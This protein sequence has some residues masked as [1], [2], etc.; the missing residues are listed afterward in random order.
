MNPVP[1]DRVLPHA[2]EA[3]AAVLGAM[4]IAP[5]VA[6]TLV[7]LLQPDYFY[8]PAHIQLYREITGMVDR[9][10]VVDMVTLSTRLHSLHLLDDVGGP[11]YLVGLL[12]RTP[13]AANVEHYATIVRDRWFL[14]QLILVGSEI[15]S[16]AFEQE[17]D[18][19]AALNE[20][21]AAMFALTSKKHG[22]GTLVPASAAVNE[23][24]AAIQVILQNDG[25]PLGLPT[26]FRKLDRMTGGLMGS[27]VIILGGRASHGKTSLLM[28][29]LEHLAVDQQIPSA[30]FS[31]E[32]GRPELM[33][34]LLCTRAQV[35]IIRLRDGLVEGA[36]LAQ[37]TA[38]GSEIR[39]S[40][41]IIDETPGLTIAQL[42]SRARQLV[43]RDGVKAIGVDY[44]QL[45]RCPSKRAE[46]NR[47]WEMNDVSG[48]VKALAK[49]LQI[50]ILLGAQINRDPE[51]RSDG[52]PR[53]A[54]LRE[55][56][57]IE[58]DADVVGLIHRPCMY[59]EDADPKAAKLILAKQRNGPTGEID[60]EFDKE[61][62]KFHDPRL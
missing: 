4:L 37:L 5:T 16:R 43:R 62:T 31:L 42:R 14:R 29:I 38:V 11:A 41:L 12:Q 51:R 28:N 18:V 40:P 22:A 59:K 15:S 19:G 47:T 13:T 17:A 2:P 23:A 9:G 50:P 61:Y 30:V 35:D 26:G 10:E 3:E 24:M 46:I 55:S 39:K 34:R 25:R 48:G 44:L 33:Q 1:L 57:A 20:A 21:E 45:L 52:K 36:E 7:E 54:D 58:Q 60:L 32:M 49:E 8:Q 6:T 56:G 53:L 27:Q